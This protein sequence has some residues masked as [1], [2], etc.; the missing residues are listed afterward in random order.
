[1]Y[2]EHWSDACA[3]LPLRYHTTLRFVPAGTANWDVCAQKGIGIPR[4][5]KSKAE[6]KRSAFETCKQRCKLY[7]HGNLV[8]IE[9]Q[10]TLLTLLCVRPQLPSISHVNLVRIGSLGS[11]VDPATAAFPGSFASLVR[12]AQRESMSKGSQPWRKG[13]SSSCQCQMNEFVWAGEHV[14]FFIRR[15]SRRSWR[16]QAY[17]QFIRSSYDSRFAVYYQKW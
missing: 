13:C 17:P 14:R 6:V 5:C 11:L 12:L 8:Q 9:S 2:L 16:A 15:S 10:K 1:M 3:I 7:D 4:F